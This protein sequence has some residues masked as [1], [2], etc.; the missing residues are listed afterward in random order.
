MDTQQLPQHNTLQAPMPEPTNEFQP[1]QLLVAKTDLHTYTI[2]HLLGWIE[3]LSHLINTEDWP[4]ESAEELAYQ[5]E[6]L[7]LPNQ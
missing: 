3:S 2:Q 7:S 5:L 1:M 6:K 4:F